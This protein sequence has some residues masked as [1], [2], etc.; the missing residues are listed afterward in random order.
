MK[1]PLPLVTDLSARRHVLAE[2]LNQLP[3]IGLDDAVATHTHYCPKCR[4]SR[5]GYN[6]TCKDAQLSLCGRCLAAGLF[7]RS[8]SDD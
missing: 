2:V 7:E 4:C 3:H 5:L 6:D 8:R 1:A